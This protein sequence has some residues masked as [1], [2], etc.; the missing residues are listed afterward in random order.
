MKKSTLILFLLA[1]ILGGLVYYYEFKHPSKPAETEDDSKALYTFDANDITR[2]EIQRGSDTMVFERKDGGWVITQPLQTGADSML[3][4]GLAS[5][6]SSARSTRSLV[7]NPSEMAAYGLEK[8]PVQVR[9]QL[10][11]GQKHEIRLGA[12]DFSGGNVYAQTDGDAKNVLLVTQSLLG[13]A[14]KPVSDFR[15]KN[16]LDVNGSDINWFE[17]KNPTGDIAGSR[18]EA[19]RWMLDKPR[20]ASGN[21]GEISGILTQASVAKMTSIVSET[22]EDLGKYGLTTPSI[23]LSVRTAK[24]ETKT[25]LVGKKADDDYFARDSSR[26]MIFKVGADLVKKLSEGLADLRDKSLISLRAQDLS[27]IEIHTAGQTIAAVKGKDSKWTLDQPADQKGKAVQFWM[28][29]NPVSSAT[30]T[31]ILDN[32]PASVTALLAKPAAEVTLTDNSGKTT[33]IAFSAVSGESTY[34][35]VDGSTDVYKL[36][37]AI[38]D[39]LNFKLADVLEP[40]GK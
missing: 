21:A 25:L 4:D 23:T 3:L 39:Q 2:I 8:P 32:A 19:D 34:A 7:A 30:A 12:A 37:K 29:F 26:P 33:R 40:P 17:L 28:L 35:R 24:G 10:K 15:D 18:Q 38:L 27:R 11:N 13:G 16:V 22:P 1:V 14:D 36:D 6:I 31:E 9:F 20:P 5:S